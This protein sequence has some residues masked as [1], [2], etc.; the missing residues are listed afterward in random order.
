MQK[1]FSDHNKLFFERCE[2]VS[3]FTYGEFNFVKTIQHA[4]VYSNSNF[5]NKLLKNYFHW[6]KL[7]LMYRYKAKFLLSK[8]RGERQDKIILNSIVFIDNGRERYDERNS[9]VS[10]YYTKFYNLLERNQFSVLL[11]KNVDLLPMKDYDLAKLKTNFKPPLL[12]Q[13]SKEILTAIKKVQL[14][15]QKSRRFTKSETVF[16]NHFFHLFF[17]DFLFYDFILSNNSVKTLVFDNHYHNEGLIAAFKAHNVNCIEIQHGLLTNNDLYYVYPKF[18]LPIAQKAFFADK[19]IVYGEYWKQKLLNG[20]E[21]SEK[22]IEVI[23]DYTYSKPTLNDNPTKRDIIFVGTQ[24]FMG[25]FYVEYLKKMAE[26]VLNNHPEWIIYV[27]L[28]PSEPDKKQYEVLNKFAN[29]KIIGN[30]TDLMEILKISKIQISYYSTTLFDAIGLGVVNFSIQ[31][32]SNYSD[33][34]LEMLEGGIALPLQ[35][36]EDPIAK[37]LENASVSQVERD[38]IY[39]D[40]NESRFRELVLN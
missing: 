38:F 33:Y 12:S 9:A 26:V 31:N 14:K 6:P 13:K 20:S 29:I 8:I 5:K 4:L 28:H 34:C 32:H 3:I 36:D 1:S 27:K 37:F 17:Q 19:I 18:V 39:A 10:M 2:D 11:K 24:K 23:G 25:V 30:E 21:Y 22:Q 15:I 40:F 35:V 7:L 16:I